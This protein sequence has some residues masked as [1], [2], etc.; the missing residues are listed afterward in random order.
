MGPFLSMGPCPC[1]KQVTGSPLSPYDVLPASPC[2]RAVGGCK[3]SVRGSVW[4]ALS[5]VV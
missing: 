5:L 2:M 3:L 4:R 1:L